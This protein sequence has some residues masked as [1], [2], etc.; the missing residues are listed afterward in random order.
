[1]VVINHAKKLLVKR[2]SKV[3]ATWLAKN[4]ISIDVA[5]LLVAGK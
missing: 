1:M 2:G 5:M 3:A 4:G